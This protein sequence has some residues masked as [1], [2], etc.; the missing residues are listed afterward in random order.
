MLFQWRAVKIG[1]QLFNGV[2]TFSDILY[3][4]YVGDCGCIVSVI[5][6]LFFGGLCGF[7]VSAVAIYQAWHDNQT[8]H[9]NG[10]TKQIF[11][12]YSLSGV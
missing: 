2:Q 12:D 10:D 6:W 5:R 3:S 1:Q 7:S 8:K 11:H 4:V 9:N